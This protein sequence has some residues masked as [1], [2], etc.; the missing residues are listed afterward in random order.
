MIQIDKLEETDHSQRRKIK[1]SHGDISK[2]LSTP[3]YIPKLRK[4]WELDL[5]CEG[6]FSSEGIQ[7]ICFDIATIEKVVKKRESRLNHIPL[8]REKQIDPEYKAV[9]D[10]YP[11]IIDPNTECFYYQSPL[12]ESYKK[13][14]DL[15]KV[16]Q[17]LL[18]NCNTQNHF[19]TWKKIMEKDRSFTTIIDWHITR[20]SKLGADIIIPPTNYIDGSSPVLLKYAKQINKWTALQALGH[21]RESAVYYP[22]NWTI[23]KNNPEYAD[24]ILDELF[25]MDDD[26]LLKNIRFVYIKIKNYDIDKDRVARQALGKFFTG[27]GSMARETGRAVFLLDIDSLGYFSLTNGIDG[28]V[29]PLNNQIRDVYGASSSNDWGLW[30]DPENHDFIR[31]RDLRK[32]FKARGVIPCDCRASK[33]QNKLGLPKKQ[34]DYALYRRKHLLSS[35]SDSIIKFHH[36]IIN[37]YPRGISADILNSETNKNFL[38]LLPNGII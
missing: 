16:M 4:D 30:Y 13:L 34:K 3:C 21:D 9:K 26:D 36:M 33:E 8:F 28:F 6:E 17:D 20:Q 37:N 22:I 18:I 23:F 11:W 15:P 35:R 29:E 1:I 32:I 5:F 31:F 27:L 7:G 14:S 38:D 24:E 10:K 12:R 2:T 19:P 25:F